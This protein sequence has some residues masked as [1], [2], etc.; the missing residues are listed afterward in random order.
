MIGQ[1]EVAKDERILGP[2]MALELIQR[3]QKRATG[4]TL[5][6]AKLLDPR[7]ENHQARRVKSQYPPWT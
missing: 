5:K 4:R 3:L 6:I 1:R 2:M 7:P